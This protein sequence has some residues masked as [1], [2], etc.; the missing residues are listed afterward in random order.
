MNSSDSNQK[1]KC[2]SSI[3]ARFLFILGQTAVCSLVYTEFIASCVK[4]SNCKKDNRTIC[5]PE[6]IESSPEINATDAME[7]EMGMSAAQDADDERV[8]IFNCLNLFLNVY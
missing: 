4:K 7:E 1:I 5:T 2:N 3:I 8:C 6:T